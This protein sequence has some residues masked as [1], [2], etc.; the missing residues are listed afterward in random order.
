MHRKRKRRQLLKILCKY[1]C[2]LV[3]LRKLGRP[4]LVLLFQATTLTIW[5][6]LLC[7]Y[8]CKKNA[9]VKL[10]QF[11]LKSTLYLGIRR[12][13]KIDFK[14]FHSV[15]LIIEIDKYFVNIFWK[16]QNIP[17]Y[18]DVVSSELTK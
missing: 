12:L 14:V 2:K 1:L 10:Y 17:L 4:F 16:R 5:G 13:K 8:D 6:R 3:F 18:I 9:C 11:V 7:R 15:T